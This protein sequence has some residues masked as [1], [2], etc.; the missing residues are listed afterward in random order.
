MKFL[1]LYPHRMLFS[2]FKIKPGLLKA[3]DQMGYTEATAI[4]EQ[5]LIPALAG[6]NI[7]G[8]AQTGT[9]KTTAFLLPLLQRIDTNKK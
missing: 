6:K 5:V 7:V 3:L 9:G 8:Q 1:L 4:Q 2:E